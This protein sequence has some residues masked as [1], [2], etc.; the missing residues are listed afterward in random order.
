MQSKS[1]FLEDLAKV[2]NSAISSLAGLK[3]EIE[4]VVRHK[5]ENYISELDL[6]KREEFDITKNMVSKARSEQ[7]ALIKRIE[8]LESKL[9]K[10]TT[11]SKR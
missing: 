9:S 1:R 3:G 2:A 7:D 11:S 10:K 5:I 8:K 4:V 6:V